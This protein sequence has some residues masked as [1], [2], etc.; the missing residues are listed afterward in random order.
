[1]ELLAPHQRGHGRA[2]GR[3]GDAPDPQALLRDAAACFDHARTQ[4]GGRPLL[5]LGHSLGGLIAARLVAGA[6]QGDAFGREPDALILSSPA[7]DGRMSR[8]QKGL[9]AVARRLFP[10][11]PVSNGLQPA[12]ISRNPAVVNAYVRDPLV[13]DRISASVAALVAD[14]GPR[15]LAAAP[16]WRVP[17]LLLWAGADRCV[18]PR[19]SQALYDTAPRALLQGQ[20]FPALAHEIFNEPEREQV[21]SALH[22]WLSLRLEP[23]A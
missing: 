18:A 12:W 13:H 9:L 3:R 2:P 7:L 6:L 17:T 4:A 8:A 11:L 22:A 14:E 16:R 19:G 23:A 21:L 15:V 20:C 5:L 10:H 1:V